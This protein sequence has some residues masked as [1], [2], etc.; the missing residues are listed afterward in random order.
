MVILLEVLFIICL[1]KG[2]RVR[3]GEYF[4]RKAKVLGLGN[5]NNQLDNYIVFRT[6]LRSKYFIFVFL[7]FS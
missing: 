3:E 6:E 4:I 1:Q 5:L 7:D 2:K